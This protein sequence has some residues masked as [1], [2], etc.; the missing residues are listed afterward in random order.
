MSIS[1]ES[2]VDAA[3]TVSQPMSRRT[4]LAQAA[5]AGI[6]MGVLR[7]MPSAQ[8]A[9]QPKQPIAETGRSYPMPTPNTKT[10]LQFRIGVMGPAM[11]SLVTSQ[12]AVDKATSPA[13]REFA[14]FELREAIGV[15]AVLKRNKTP[16]P[17]MSASAKATLA[18]IKGAPKGAAF[19]KAYMTAQLANHEFLRDH[20]EAYLANS[21]GMMGMAEMHTQDLAMLAL[22]TFKEHVVHCKNFLGIKA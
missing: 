17:P 13:A 20:A 18:K 22:G 2:T 5:A 19:D 4:L 11:L 9:T 3:D 6:G 15:I 1:V 8:A 16:V 14:N 10:E 7:L 21:K 12:I